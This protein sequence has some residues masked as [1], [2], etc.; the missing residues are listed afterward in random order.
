LNFFRTGDQGVILPS[1]YLQITGRLKELINGGGEKISPLEIDAAMLRIDGVAEAV[2]F[3]V[4]DPKYGEVVWAG[5]V[6][7]PGQPAGAE[8][9]IKLD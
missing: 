7:K 4:E 5:V 6:P 3:G 9:K 8:D 2:C 1:G